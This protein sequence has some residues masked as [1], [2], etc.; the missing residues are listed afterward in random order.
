MPFASSRML[1][2]GLALVLAWRNPVNDTFTRIL[3]LVGLAGIWL[4]ILE[5]LW[6]H[7]VCRWAWLALPLGLADL[8]LMPGQSPVK[9]I[10]MNYVAQLAK[11]EGSPYCWGGESPLGIDCSG[12]PRRALREAMLIEGLR[13]ADG[14]I[15]RK[16]LVHWWID[17]SARDLGTG[18]RNL[19]IPLGIECTIAEADTAALQPGDLAVTLGGVYVMVFLGDDHW[20]QADPSQGQVVIEHGKKDPNPWFDN[21]VTLHRWRLES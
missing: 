17:A 5:Y 8:L 18:K 2:A 21:P 16:A 6:K 14:A 15:L 19:T 4:G 9:E 10:Q 20:I 3:L 13:H 1:L 12:L 7:R 11:Y